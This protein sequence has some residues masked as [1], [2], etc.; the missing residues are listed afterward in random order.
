MVDLENKILKVVLQPKGAELTSIYRKQN[1]LEYMWGG[2]PNV[3]GKH[4]PVLFPIVGTLKENTFLYVGKK[5]H[6]PRH[7][8][9]RDKVFSIIEVAS[10]SVTF[11]LEDDKETYEV[12][13]FHF[14]VFLTLDYGL[15]KELILF[16]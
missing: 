5:Y 10:D 7:G 1:Q 11:L 12:Y 2:D 8:F 16:A 3:W 15:Q 9:A 14:M 13:P 6:L 4:S